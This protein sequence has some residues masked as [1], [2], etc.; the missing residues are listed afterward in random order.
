MNDFD[1]DVLQRR[2]ISRGAKHKVGGSKSKRCSLPSDGMTN[3]QWKERNGEVMTFNIKKRTDW[4]TFKT[5]SPEIKTEYLT[6]LR[7]EY[8]ATKRMICEMF[9]ICYTTL[10]IHLQECGINVGFSK[11]HY[12]REKEQAREARWLA[13]LGITEEDGAE[14][15]Y[16]DGLVQEATPDH[17]DS[18]NQQ[19]DKGQQGMSFDGFTARFSGPFDLVSL[20]NSL[21]AV[22]ADGEMVRIT[23][24][25]EKD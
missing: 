3:K 5:L 18:S 24:I 8:G 22:I 16:S 15:Q 12:T 4:K 6:K 23:V 13:F 17:T 1:W 19:I 2:R 11:T 9:G 25:C 14:V 10:N 20:C 7:D 21:A